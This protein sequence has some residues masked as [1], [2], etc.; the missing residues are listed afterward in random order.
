MSVV[1]DPH[2]QRGVVLV[3][4]LL[5]LLVLGVIAA[6]MAR[7]SLLELRMAGNEE[8]RIAALQ[9][10]L[11]GIDAVL[12]DPANLPPASTLGHRSC[13]DGVTATG[14][15]DHA[16]TIASAALPATGDLDLAAVRVA[17]LAGP[18]P[19]MA[20]DRASSAIH[21]VVGKFE[22]QA[23]YDGSGEQRGHAALAQG[24]LVRQPASVRTGEVSP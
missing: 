15:D 13:L 8:A 7:T 18:M 16:I 4:S 24:V 14:C 3:V 20:Q 10:A 1:H 9:Q 5:V 6:T 11:T 22:V 17:P 19:V 2:S 21:Y 12:A 23:R